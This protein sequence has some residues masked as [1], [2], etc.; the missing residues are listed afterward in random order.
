MDSYGIT[1][2]F[3]LGIMQYSTLFSMDIFLEWESFHMEGWNES[4]DE[5]EQT[6]FVFII[7]TSE[8]SSSSAAAAEAGGQM[9]VI[10]Y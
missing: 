5:Y 6:H 10:F 7:T 3:I 4:Q 9:V 2:C 1:G 8:G